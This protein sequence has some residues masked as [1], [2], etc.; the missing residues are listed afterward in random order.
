[1]ELTRE[2]KLAFIKDRHLILNANAGSGKTSVLVEKYL[3][4]ILD[5]KDPISPKDIVAITFTEASANE[6]KVRLIKKIDSLL[7]ESYSYNN[8]N[9]IKLNSIKREIISARIS[10]IH[11][12]C[13]GIIKNYPIESDFS[14]NSRLIDAYNKNKLIEE[15]KEIVLENI[16]KNLNINNLDANESYLD[17]YNSQN[18]IQFLF[19]NGNTNTINSTFEKIFK[20]SFTN[21]ENIRRDLKEYY[22]GNKI[23]DISIIIEKFIK[24]C[25]IILENRELVF[26]KT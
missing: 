9:E 2:Q 14:P 23:F 25:Q 18:T 21:L 11:S 4:L 15:S 6:M 13:N 20:Y 17:L 19:L 8:I 22:L 3:D 16:F 5:A 24:Y 1:M 26:K 7:K 12:F 10:T